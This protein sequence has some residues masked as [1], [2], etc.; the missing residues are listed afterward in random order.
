M[1]SSKPQPKRALSQEEPPV[2]LLSQRVEQWICHGARQNSGWLESVA[3][4]GFV[5]IEESPGNGDP[6]CLLT[7]CGVVECLFGGEG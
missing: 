5:E 1:K 6:G 3:R 7:E 2:L 4:D